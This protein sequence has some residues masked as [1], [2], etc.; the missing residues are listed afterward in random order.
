MVPRRGRY[1][2]PQ[3]QFTGEL[4]FRRG[5]GYH[6]STYTIPKKRRMRSTNKE[7]IPERTRPRLT[8][9][10]PVAGKPQG[11]GALQYNAKN[12]TGGQITKLNN[13]FVLGRWNVRTLYATG[14]L[15]ELCYEMDRYRWNVLGLCEVRWPGAGEVGT[16]EGHRLW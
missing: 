2:N 14:K 10:A 7:H 1:R 15:K 13:E 16:D 4:T 9:S 11:D 8:T 12:A 5:D 3:A 6:P